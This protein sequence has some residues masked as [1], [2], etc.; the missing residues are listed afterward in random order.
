MAI[1]ILAVLI[2]LLCVHRV[3][4]RTSRRPRTIEL[5]LRSPIYTIVMTSAIKLRKPTDLGS[6]GYRSTIY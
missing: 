3:Y 2:T 1:T 5:E 6:L 4:L